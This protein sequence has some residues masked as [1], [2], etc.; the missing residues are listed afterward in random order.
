M[1]ASGLLKLRRSSSAAGLHSSRRQQ[2]VQGGK[3]GSGGYIHSCRALQAQEYTTKEDGETQ[4]LDYRVF[5]LD[6]SGKTVSFFVARAL[7]ILRRLDDHRVSHLSLS[8]SGGCMNCEVGNWHVILLVV[9]LA[10]ALSV[11]LSV[12]VSS[13][14]SL[15]LCLCV[16]VAEQ[17]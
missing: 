16:S 13:T 12:R 17:M 9:P 7:H 11:C 1:V 6:K 10:S 4:T 3:V 14:L 8:L 5:F 15:A 2:Q